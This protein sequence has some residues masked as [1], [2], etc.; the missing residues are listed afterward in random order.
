MGKMSELD[1]QR[2][3]LLEVCR[4]VEVEEL[5]K[6]E[7]LV[8]NIDDTDT[9]HIPVYYSIDDETGITHYDTD[10]M[11]DFFDKEIKQLEDNTQAEV[12]GWNEKQQDYAMDSMA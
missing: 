2:R 9:I 3:E 1:R 5:V 10:S 8:K 12:D 6:K 7:E 4:E 11:R